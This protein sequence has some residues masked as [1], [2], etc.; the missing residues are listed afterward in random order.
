MRFKCE[1]HKG[2]SS[3]IFAEEAVANDAAIRAGRAWFGK[4]I[5]RARQVGRTE[6]YRLFELAGQD[7]LGTDII[8]RVSVDGPERKAKQSSIEDGF[9]GFCRKCKVDRADAYLHTCPACS[10]EFCLVCGND[11]PCGESE[12]K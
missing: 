12:G 5:K 9:S 7:G 6:D 2:G 10:L 4:T 8:V 11:H 1:L 3:V